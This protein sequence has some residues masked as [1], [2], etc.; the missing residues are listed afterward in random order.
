MRQHSKDTVAVR[1]FVLS[2]LD[3]FLKYRGYE[4]C[5]VSELRQFFSYL[6][7]GHEEAG[8]RWGNAQLTRPMRPV[9]VATYHKHVRTL[10]S[11][12]VTEGILES[13][14]MDRIPPPV[15]RSDQVRPFTPDQDRAILEAAQRSRHRR[16]DEA[17]VL[18]LLDTGLRASEV[19][20]L[21]FTDVD[22]DG[23]RCRVLGK[24]NKYR[25][26]YFGRNCAKALWQYLKAEPHESDEPLFVSDRGT[27]AG[28]AF[29]RN[30]LFQLIQRLGVAAGIQATRCSPH[31]FRHTFAV[32]FLRAGGNTFTLKELL[33]HTSLHLTNKYVALAQADLEAQHRAFSPGDRTKRRAA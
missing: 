23:R 13:S 27:S 5:G 2:K 20:N 21:R 26:V 7:R 33:G 4:V 19:C 16:R 18:F 24:G 11:W 1:R 17:I 15:V 28:E 32:E 3:W 29:T 6:S 10:F 31:T 30:G 8:G 9:T 22:L 25:T 14:P 12:I